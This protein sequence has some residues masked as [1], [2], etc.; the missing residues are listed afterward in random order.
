MGCYVDLSALNSALKSKEAVNNVLLTASEDAKQ[1]IQ[2]ELVY[3]RNVVEVIDQVVAGELLIANASTLI[4]LFTLLI[5]LSVV[6]CFGIIYNVSRISAVEKFRELVTM[7]VI[8]FTNKEVSE[9]GA[10]ENWLLFI[11]SIF[12]GL[13]LSV[14]LKDPLASVVRDESFSLVMEISFNSILFAILCCMVAVL[15]SN[16]ISTKQI[17]KYNIIEAIKEKS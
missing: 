2:Q 3:A 7:K 13:L 17:K 8:G 1:E 11:P 6:M 4:M 16:Y 12:G 15:L 5:I 9:I 14:L 10:F